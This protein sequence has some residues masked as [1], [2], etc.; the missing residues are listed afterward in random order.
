[1]ATF[2]YGA[3]D[4]CAWTDNGGDVFIPLFHFMLFSIFSKVYSCLFTLP[5][6]TLTIYF[7]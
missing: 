2:P 1:M 7:F 4:F 5:V 6:V 3:I